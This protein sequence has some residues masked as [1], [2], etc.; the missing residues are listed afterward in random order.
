MKGS[1][2][3]VVWDGQLIRLAMDAAEQ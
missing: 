2:I 3:G 1:K